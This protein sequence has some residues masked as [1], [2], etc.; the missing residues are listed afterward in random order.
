MLRA[1]MAADM[2]DIAIA[3][4]GEHAGPRPVM[5]QYGVGTDRRAVQ[6]MVD[7]RTRQVEPRAQLANAGDHAARRVVARRRGFVDQGPAGFGVGKDEVREG[8]AHV[9]PD[10]LHIPLIKL[11]GATHS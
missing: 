4:G 1:L 8:A 11:A 6:Y 7:R 5:L 2:D 3:G 10:Q 9:D